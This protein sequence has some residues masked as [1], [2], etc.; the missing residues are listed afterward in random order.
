MTIFHRLA[1]LLRSQLSGAFRRIFGDHL[2]ADRG[3]FLGGQLGA[4]LLAKLCKCR[5]AALHGLLAALFHGGLLLFG[6]LG[7][8]ATL[9]AL[10]TRS[11]GFRWF[12]GLFCLWCLGRC[13]FILCKAKTGGAKKGTKG[14]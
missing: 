3:N 11:F 14:E 8:L 12:R 6:Q 5:S 2:G 1:T 9:A 4:R 13:F 7:T 10:A